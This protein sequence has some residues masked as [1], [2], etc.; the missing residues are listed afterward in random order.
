MV[1]CLRF[2]GIAAATARVPMCSVGDEMS[3]NVDVFLVLARVSTH[4]VGEEMLPP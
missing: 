1:L 3:A 4:S 2:A